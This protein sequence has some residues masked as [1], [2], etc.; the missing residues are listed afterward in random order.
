MN[1]RTLCLGVLSLGDATGYEIKKKLQSRFSHFYD[2][3]FGSIYPALARLTGEGLVSFTPEPQA[4]R[5]GKKV[6]RV[7][8]AGHLAF[9][10]E[11]LGEPAPDRVRSEFLVI[12]TFS[13]LLPPQALDQL[14]DARLA[15]YRERIAALE[16]RDPDEITEGGAFVRGFGLAIYRAAVEFIENNRHR[17]VAE[18]FVAGREAGAR[19]GA[20]AAEARP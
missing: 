2:A 17:V 6:Y 4:G 15:S 11:L 19:E 3:S 20:A 12:M 1:V 5:P 16:P 13:E 7:T 8:P 14:F 18:Q 9:A 10:N